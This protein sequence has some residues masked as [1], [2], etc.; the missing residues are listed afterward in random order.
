M[1]VSPDSLR[2]LFFEQSID[3]FFIMMLDEPIEWNDNAPKDAILEHVFH[4]QR[5]TIANEAYARQYGVAR[6]DLIGMTPAEFF[7]HDLTAGGFRN[8]NALETYYGVRLLS[9]AAT[10]FVSLP[11]T[12]VIPT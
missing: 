4:H 8:H 7:R 5:M 9:A 11:G 10:F 12:R 1:S 2:E 3:G 6:T